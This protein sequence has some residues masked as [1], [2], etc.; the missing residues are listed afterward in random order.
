MNSYQYFHPQMFN[1]SSW[2]LEVNVT[3]EYNSTS[4]DMIKKRNH[5]EKILTAHVFILPVDLSTTAINNVE[6]VSLF[7]V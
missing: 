2:Q 1:L 6:S 5:D 3:E 7:C 4:T